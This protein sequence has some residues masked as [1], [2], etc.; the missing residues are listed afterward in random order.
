VVSKIEFL[1]QL[2]IFSDLF[3]QELEELARITD[4]YK[5]EKGAA[6]AYQ[7]DIADRFYIVSRCPRSGCAGR[8]R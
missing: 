8:D 2:P 1:G 4:E 6:I 7:R 5:F 3:D